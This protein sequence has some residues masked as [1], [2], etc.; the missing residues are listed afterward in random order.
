MG[1]LQFL[2]LLMMLF[3]C[4]F[5]FFLK[6]ALV[7]FFVSL[8]TAFIESFKLGYLLFTGCGVGIDFAEPLLAVFLMI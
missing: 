6:F 7:L 8:K 1:I 4:N 2:N 3:R 5:S